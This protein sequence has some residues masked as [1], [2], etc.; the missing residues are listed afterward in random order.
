MNIKE[1][2]DF[3][4]L[5]TL[6][7]KTS[8]I[9]YTKKNNDKRYNFDFIGLDNINLNENG[10]TININKQLEMFLL[11][12]SWNKRGISPIMLIENK[13]LI[14]TEKADILNKI[15]NELNLLFQTEEEKDSQ[16]FIDKEIELKVKYKI[17]IDKNKLLFSPLYLKILQEEENKTIFIPILFID[18]TD[19][20][21]S[22]K[23]HPYGDSDF[24]LDIDLNE[25]EFI[26]NDFA[27]TLFFNENM[28]ELFNNLLYVSNSDTISTKEEFFKK[29]YNEVKYKINKI[30]E[31]FK[32]DFPIINEDKVE[33]ICLFFNKE[34]QL[35]IKEDFKLINFKKNNLLEKFLMKTGKEIKKEN[36]DSPFFGSFTKDYELSKGQTIVMQE[37]QNNNNLISVFGGPGTGKTTLIMS[38]I[39]NNIVKRALSNI[40]LNKDYN[41][42]TLITSTSNKAIEN[43]TESISKEIS[44]DFFYLG[45]NSK[46]RNQ[47]NKKIESIISN[48]EKNEF[49]ETTFLEI[50]NRIKEIITELEN[51]HE[52]FKNTKTILKEE[53]N[54]NSI[55]NLNAFKISF[56]DSLEKKRILA[57]IESLRDYPLKSINSLLSIEENFEF[58]LKFLKH[59]NYFLLKKYSQKIENMNFFQKIIKTEN[60]LLNKFNELNKDFFII[61]DVNFIYEL[62]N[63]FEI[64]KSEEKILSENI[65]KLSDIKKLEK[66]ESLNLEE[67]E[68]VLNYENFGEYYRIRYSYLNYEL[69]ILSKNYLEMKALKKKFKII[70]SLRYLASGNMYHVKNTEEFLKDISL[71][72]PVFTSTL[73]GFKYM[74]NNLNKNQTNYIYESL[75]C[76]EAGMV[77]ITE[78]LNPITESD[79]AIIIGDPKQLP[80]IISMNKLFEN[81]LEKKFSELNKT[82]FKKYSITTISAFHR[83][84]G[85]EEGGYLSYGDSILLDEH[86]RCQEPIAK[87][88]MS[89]AEYEGIKIKTKKIPIESIYPFEH[90]LCFFDIKNKNKKNQLINEKEVLFIEKIL[91]FLEKNNFDIKNEVGIITPYVKQEELIIQKVGRKIN[92][93]FDNKKIGTV[94]KFQGTEF[95]IIIFSSVV[96][97]EEESLYFINKDPSLI[98]VAI[99]RAK[100]LFIVVGDFEKIS[101]TEPGN[102]IG[103]MSN[104][105]KKYIK[106]EL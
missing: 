2:L 47:S 32:I 77:K 12:D 13:D 68:K 66:L 85:C 14:D 5:S 42:I 59:K 43:I 49:V 80:P 3:Y 7:E 35:D 28:K 81:Y 52:Y 11:N 106:K 41:N 90:N 82:F 51:S 99:S 17:L 44:K 34:D 84:S 57:Q 69:F 87:L 95:R 88:F 24:K 54:I 61:E 27:T 38:L 46:N 23:N 30:G 29:I 56:K 6:F 50:E 15:K 9:I 67:I 89:V 19:L 58:Y 92:H 45:G 72:I 103:R 18:L 62:V 91:D 4:E 25:T 104:Q 97:T 8:Q 31:E 102:Y 33:P 36:L 16:E 70:D 40:Y 73:A 94:H 98:N 79:R 20:K 96:S 22:I 105:M 10:L 101:G 53:F 83:A 26:Y 60:S 76:D 86:R 39:S 21:Y 37:N 71:L 63:L 55:E 48:F 78:I 65:K 100:E 93:S 75:I 64:L 74:F 1:I